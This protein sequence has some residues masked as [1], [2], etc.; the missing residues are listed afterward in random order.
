MEKSS[1]DP[2][3]GCVTIPAALVHVP[4]L[5]LPG[6]GPLVAF[7]G[8]DESADDAQKVASKAGS[9]G[10]M[11]AHECFSGSKMC[12]QR[13]T[14]GGGERGGFA[15]ARDLIVTPRGALAGEGVLF[16]LPVGLDEFVA[17]KA[18]ECGIH[19][20]AG[21]AGD[22]HDIEAKAVAKAEGLEDESRA[23]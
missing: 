15:L 7:G 6:A 2:R 13:I 17:L 3:E 20:A 21:Q 1:D 18:A 23:V 9:G 10:G 5:G 8:G 19:R 16:W 22:L 4:E 14:F 11:A 12:E